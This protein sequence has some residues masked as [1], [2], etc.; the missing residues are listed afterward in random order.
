MRGQGAAAAAAGAAVRRCG[1]GAVELA[2]HSWGHSVDMGE[3]L[4]RCTHWAVGMLACCPGSATGHSGFV[5]VTHPCT[6]TPR[7]QVLPPGPPGPGQLTRPNDTQPRAHAQI[8]PAACVVA[9]AQA[10]GPGSQ[11]S[12][13]EILVS[14]MGHVW[15][16]RGQGM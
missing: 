10:G 9:A 7:S 1:G 15:H 16:L 3:H 2:E 5:R 12:T 13:Q 11:S 8:H 14:S 4:V 6:H